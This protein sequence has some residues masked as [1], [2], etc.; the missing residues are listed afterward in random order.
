MS[1]TSPSPPHSLQS[2]E[3][4]SDSISS[5]FS[6]V[7]ANP[8]CQSFEVAQKSFYKIN[9]LTS[10][11]VEDIL[12]E[13]LNYSTQ[14]NS[15]QDC[16]VEVLSTISSSF[17]QDY[18]SRDST[19]FSIHDILGLQ[20]S[21]NANNSQEE[22]QPRFEYQIPHYDNVS[23]SSNNNY[24][25][26]AEEAVSDQCIAKNSGIYTIESEIGNQD[27]YHRNYSN[28][29][30]VRCHQRSDLDNDVVK[31]P[32]RELNNIHESSFPSQ[33]KFCCSNF[34]PYCNQYTTYDKLSLE[35]E[36]HSNWCDLP[37]NNRIYNDNLIS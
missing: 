1:T 37:Q 16:K 30:L 12:S 36:R 14:D 33:V 17:V 6:E 13:G 21:C 15:F 32:E 18:N 27:I 7:T 9:S 23:N 24:T 26:G 22:L 8:N 4:S 11:G 35:Q 31:N 34:Q 28:S 20:Q 19:G 3:E 25:S 10:H 5:E 2:N 29:E